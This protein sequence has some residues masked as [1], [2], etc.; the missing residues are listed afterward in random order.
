MEPAEQGEQQTPPD[1]PTDNDQDG[2]TD[3]DNCP[4]VFNPDQ[5]DDD[6]DGIGNPCDD[7]TP[8]DGFPCGFSG[9]ATSEL[10]ESGDSS[11][12]TLCQPLTADPPPGW[13]QLG[14]VLVMN[15][16]YL[17]I[18]LTAEELSKAKEAGLETVPVDEVGGRTAADLAAIRIARDPS[19]A[20]QTA[21]PKVLAAVEPEVLEAVPAEVLAK[22]PDETLAALPEQFWIDAPTET[23]EAVGVDRLDVLYPNLPRLD[24]G[25]VVKPELEPETGRLSDG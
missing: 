8:V 13:V 11:V 15:D 16:T 18:D 21:D 24:P 19:S 12:T 9:S 10:S 4:G 23:V 7:A 1:D 22:Q 14:N 20:L 5:A 3:G 25:L 17:I 6:G 2:I